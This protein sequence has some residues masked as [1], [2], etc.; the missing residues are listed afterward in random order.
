M[1]KLG[2]SRTIKKFPE[3]TSALSLTYRDIIAVHRMLHSK[4]IHVVFI[5]VFVN[6]KYKK[7]RFKDTILELKHCKQDKRNY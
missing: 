3:L 1:T 2:A 6:H 7:T 5:L 4:S